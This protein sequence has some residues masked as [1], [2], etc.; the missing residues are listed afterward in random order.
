MKLFYWSATRNFG[1]Y[2][3]PWLWERLAPGC[4][5]GDPLTVFLGI[6]TILNQKHGFERYP[7][8]VVMGSGVGYGPLI[9]P[10][11]SW[12]FYCVR[13]PRSAQ[14][15][16]LSADLAVTDPGMLVRRFISRRYP[17][18]KFGFMP[19]FHHNLDAWRCICRDIGIAYVNPQQEVDSVLNEMLDCEVLLTEAMHGA[20]IADALGTPWVPV[21]IDQRILD[22]KWIDWCE[23]VGLTYQPHAL[24][25]LFELP[26]D[27]DFVLRQHTRVTRFI[28]RR[29][30]RRLIRQAKPVLSDR[31]RLDELEVR[32]LERIE[33]FRQDCVA[34]RL[35]ATACVP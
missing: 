18:H 11:P 2:L 34:G 15:L 33:R 21:R 13:G 14:A 25:R 7:Q 32:L 12:R 23:S 1:D 6:G 3:N 17:A 26:E 16:A 31:K 10:D 8:K 30:M 28:A 19:H 22:F 27:N 9:E 4:F 29:A 24:P 35:Q 5:D 20:I